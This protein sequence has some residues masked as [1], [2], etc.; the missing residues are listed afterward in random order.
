MF[1]SCRLSLMPVAFSLSIFGLTPMFPTLSSHA[2]EVA[3]AVAVDATVTVE[4]RVANIFQS[5]DESLVQIVVQKSELD[6]LNNAARASYPAPGTSVYVHVR[7]DNSLAGRFSRRSAGDELP[8]P[9]SLVSA[10]LELDAAGQWAAAG[11]GWFEPISDLGRP[12]TA[13]P[14]PGNLGGGTLG[15]ATQRVKLGQGTALKVVTVTP[16][17]PAA[18]AGIEPGDT[19]VQVNRQPL[20]SEEQLENVFRRSSRGITLTVRDV[21]SGRDVEVDVNA[22][23]AD[24]PIARKGG[25]RSLGVATKLAFFGGEPALE[26][27]NVDPGSPAQQ[28]GITSGLLITQANGKKVS[29]PEELQTAER[30]SR[31]RLELQ[32]IDPKERRE[33]TVRVEL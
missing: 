4:G 32:L 7:P 29:S 15:L 20:E 12:S 16:N 27:T 8:R 31:G 33:Q 22:A 30:E 13:N 1:T 28:A 26:I 10:A 14:T 18:A 25:M 17:S 2:Q 5:D 21:R 6:S 3:V 19:L 23:A 11:R 24:V 9:G